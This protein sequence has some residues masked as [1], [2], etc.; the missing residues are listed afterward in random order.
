M[1]G[2]LYAG[3]MTIIS[4]ESFSFWESVLLFMMVILGGVGALYGPLVG[5]ALFLALFHYLGTLFE[6]AYCAAPLYLRM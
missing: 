4:P 2:A 3:K 6:N 5:A 1:A